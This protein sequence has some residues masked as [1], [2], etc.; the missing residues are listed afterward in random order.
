MGLVKQQGAL[1]GSNARP[2]GILGA[3]RLPKPVVGAKSA[4]CGRRPSKAGVATEPCGCSQL[5]LLRGMR[6]E[7]RSGSSAPGPQVPGLTSPEH[8]PAPSGRRLH[9]LGRRGPLRPPPHGDLTVERLDAVDVVAVQR[10][11]RL[12]AAVEGSHEGA[13]NVGVGQAERVAELV[14]RHLEQVHACAARVGTERLG[15]HI[16]RPRLKAGSDI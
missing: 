7:R 10:E 8:D 1:T 5:F 15:F 2:A 6:L 3:A 16:T 11:S 13:S 9:G 12:V 4:S 14:G